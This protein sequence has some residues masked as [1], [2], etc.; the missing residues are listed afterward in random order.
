MSFNRLEAVGRVVGMAG[1][2]AAGWAIGTRLTG[3]FDGGSTDLAITTVLIAA[4]ALLGA[5]LTPT[6]PT[7]RSLASPTISP[8]CPTPLCR[9]SC[10]AWSLA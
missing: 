4:G 5:A 6:S 7:A 1:L 3:G 2:A 10:W 9:P 8:A